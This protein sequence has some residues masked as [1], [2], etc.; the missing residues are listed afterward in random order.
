M[1]R[2][3]DKRICCVVSQKHLSAEVTSLEIIH[4]QRKQNG[5]ERM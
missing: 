4:E 3:K 5:R 1:G 2:L